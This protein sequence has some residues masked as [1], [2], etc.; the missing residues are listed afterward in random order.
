MANRCLTN[1]DAREM[2]NSI[3]T[4]SLKGWHITLFFVLSG[5]LLMNGG[6]TPAAP[7]PATKEK[8]AKVEAHPS[9]ADIYRIVLSPKAE[10]R[11]QITTVPVEKVSVPRHRSLG[12]DIVIPD[13]RRISVTAPLTGILFEAEDSPIPAAGQQVTAKQPLLS[14]SPILR[15]EQE[16]PTAAERV[17][18]ANARATL[19]SLQIQATG[20]EKQAMARVDG[21]RIAFER[22]KRLLADKAGSQRDVDDTEATLNI[23]QEALEAARERRQ[24]L[25]KLTLEAETGEIPTIVIEAPQAGIVQ[26]V[27]ARVGQPVSAGAML[28]EIVDLSRMWVRVPV[29]AGLVD[30]LDRTASVS[31]GAL[32]STGETVEASP[33]AAPPTATALSAS[34]DLYYEVDNSDSR[35]RPGERVAVSVMLR[36]EKESL[37]VPRAAVLRD[38]HGTA[39]VYVK[40]GDHEFRRERISVTFNTE[41]LAVLSHGPDI[42]TPVVVDGAAELFGTEFGAGK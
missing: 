17:Q 10:E 9:E 12:G 5:L 20:D 7:K 19:V 37:V 8:P 24:M 32:S 29:Y 35:F 30:E 31:V 16:V 42:G 15:P 4:D 21:A 2:T 23:A 28:F 34:V 22:A 1:S 18:M 11:L 13:G 38:I 41:D 6:C 26:T 36:G 40:A 14:L 27:S 25:D 3:V 33:V 39:W